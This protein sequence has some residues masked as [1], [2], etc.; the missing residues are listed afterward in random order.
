MTQEVDAKRP[1]FVISQD[2]SD[3]YITAEV[4]ITKT[5]DG[6]VTVTTSLDDMENRGRRFAIRLTQS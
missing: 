5:I 2:G 4:R 3:L 6:R 1:V